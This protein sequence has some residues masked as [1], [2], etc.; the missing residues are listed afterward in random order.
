MEGRRETPEDSTRST[1]RAR[2]KRRI[3]GG[4][5]RASAW[6]KREWG[7]VAL[8]VVG[9]VMVMWCSWMVVWPQW[10]GAAARRGIGG[11]IVNQFVKSWNGIPCFYSYPGG[12][13]ALMGACFLHR[14]ADGFEDQNPVPEGRAA[15]SSERPDE[16][17]MDDWFVSMT[18]QS[19]DD[20]WWA[21]TLRTNEAFLTESLIEQVPR[22][23]QNG[24]FPE[25]VGAAVRWF[26]MTELRSA[27]DQRFPTCDAEALARDGV[28]RWS[29][30]VWKGHAINVATV[31]GLGMWMWFTPVVVM[32]VVR[33]RR[34]RRRGRCTKCMYDVR[35]LAGSVCPECGE[36]L[37]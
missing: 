32:D 25:D 10:N 36:T 18:W 35:G 4:A 7:H 34:E 29:D 11:R 31:V 27:V 30:V 15:V 22:P 2:R 6:G 5:A 8:S 37:I 16:G 33:W 9:L 1:R 19:W 24:P 13:G 20:G 12:G 17:A 23:R 26:A 14:T 21:T 28:Y 3:V